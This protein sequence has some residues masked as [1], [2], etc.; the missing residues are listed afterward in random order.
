MP[1][2]SVAVNP[3]KLS[4]AAREA[5]DRLSR[6][7]KGSAV[8]EQMVLD[9]HTILAALDQLDALAAPEPQH[10]G[11]A[12]L[13]EIRRRATA[14]PRATGDP[15]Y[16]TDFMEL[17]D[18]IRAALRQRQPDAE[19]VRAAWEG[20]AKLSETVRRI[21][22]LEEAARPEIAPI[23]PE[24]RGALDAIAAVLPPEKL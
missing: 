15:L 8:T 21:A 12:A 16:S 18:M 20:H 24:V 11:E 14:A 17:V 10:A 7:Q 23:I 9:R 3:E 1:C 19:K 5:T 13:E 22:T 6:N 4:E 2:G